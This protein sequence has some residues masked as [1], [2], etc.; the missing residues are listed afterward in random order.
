M[1]KE[2]VILVLLSSLILPGALNAQ[3]YLH[4]G[5]SGVL[6]DTLYYVDGGCLIGD[7]DLLIIEAGATLVFITGA[8]FDV[9]GCLQAMG[10]QEDTIKFLL[11]PGVDDWE[12]L[13][14]LTAADS[15]RLEYVYLEGARADGVRASDTNLLISHCVIANN[16]DCNGIDFD[17]SNSAV[18]NCTIRN[19]IGGYS[20]GI[21][22]FDS[23]IDITD[24]LIA[25]NHADACG[26]GIRIGDSRVVIRDCIFSGNSANFGAGIYCEGYDSLCNVTV[27][28]CLIEGNTA[29]EDGGGVY[30]ETSIPTIENCTISGNSAQAHGAG[31]WCRNTVPTI[32]NTIVEGSRLGSAVLIQNSLYTAVTYCDFYDNLEGDFYGD[33]PEGLGV[34]TTLNANGDSCDIFHNIFLDPEFVDPLVGNYHLLAT[35]PC[36]DAGDPTSPLDPDSTIADIGAFYFDQTMMVPQQL[37]FWQPTQSGILTNYPNPFNTSTLINYSLTNASQVELTISNILGQRIAI[38]VSGIQPAGTHHIIWDA[39]RVASGIYFAQLQIQKK[40]ESRKIL[41]IK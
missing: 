34:V 27:T 29:G 33:L 31:I 2:I 22:C 1:Q 41:L 5:L 13:F 3:I 15:S 20:G 17:N 16:Y 38:L 35:S 40:S 7:S 36:I 8:W 4:G 32:V 18:K 39:S 37:G 30:F 9:Y 14:F 23:D 25:N 24:C 6:E 12:G 21:H 26:G 19:N 10:T 11:G 28:N